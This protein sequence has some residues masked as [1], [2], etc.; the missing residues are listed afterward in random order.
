MSDRLRASLLLLVLLFPFTI[1]NSNAHAAPVTDRPISRSSAVMFVENVD[2]WP[3]AARFQ[4]RSGGATLWLAESALWITLVE[5]SVDD[6]GRALGRSAPAH[7]PQDAGLNAERI[8]RRGANIRLSFVDGKSH[9][10]LEPFDRLDTVVS[11]FTSNDPTRWRP[12]VPAWG[13]VRYADLYP[14]IDFEVTSEGG[15]LIHRLAARPG[16]DLAAVTLRVE[17][18]DDVAIAGHVLRL[19]AAGRD[20]IFPLPR[21]DGMLPAGREAHAGPSVEAL[22]AQTFDVR[23]P[24]AGSPGISPPARSE[25]F[26]SAGNSDRVL[27]STFLGGSDAD[28]GPEIAVDET[29]SAYLAGWT[30]SSDF[31][32][33][34]GAFDPSHNGG[35][36]VYVAKLNPNGSALAYATFLGGGEDKDPDYGD[37]AYGVAVDE[38]GC[39]HVVGMTNSSDFPTTPGAFDTSHNGGYDGFV[40]KLDPTGAQL[41]YATLL[42]GTSND[43]GHDIALDG[44]GGAHVI[45]V[46]YSADFPVTSGVFDASYNGQGSYG[47]TFVA[48]LDP[49]GSSLTHATFLGGSSVDTGAAIAVDGSGDIYVAGDTNSAD[50]PATL[51]AYDTSHNG[52]KD[53]F[54]VKLNAAASVLRYATFIGGSS[55]DFGRDFA[56]DAAGS[57]YVTGMTVSGD[58]PTTPGAWDR[59]LGA[60]DAYVVKLDSAG[61]QL[62][63]ATLLGG[64]SD[65]YGD[66]IAVDSTGNAYVTGGTASDDFPLTPGA[67]DTTYGGGTCDTPAEHYPCGDA[68]AVKLEPDGSALADGT[69]LGGADYDH[70]YGIAV[71]TAG[72]MYVTGPTTSADFVTTPGAFDVEVGYL[73]RFVTKLKPSSY[74]PSH[75]RWTSLASDGAPVARA[76]HSAVWTGSEMIV[77]GGWGGLP[78]DNTFSD[79]GRYDPRT[80][81][82]RAMSTGNAPSARTKQAAVWTG[83]EMIVWGG[84]GQVWMPGGFL[85]DGGRYNPGTDTWAPL[86]G[87][88]AP[89]ARRP[90]AA[91]WTGSELIVWGGY[92]DSFLDDGAAYNP[93]TDRW[94]SISTEGAPAGRDQAAAIWTGS[95][96]IVWGGFGGGYRNDGARYDPA[97][98][99]WTPV[100]VEGAPSART[101]HTAI[102]TGS[103]M[104]IWGGR[105]GGLLDDGAAYDPV[106]DSWAALP[107]VDAPT[108]RANH[109]AVWNGSD[110]LVWGGWSGQTSGDGKRYNPEIRR[111]TALPAEGAPS[112]RWLHTAVWSGSEM[113][114]WGGMDDSFPEGGTILNDGASFGEQHTNYLPLLLK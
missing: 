3:S 81:R 87:A 18:A 101:A 73:D 23:A 26:A 110:M 75:A 4:A 48:R 27:Y 83:A 58:F 49:L 93:A 92:N 28:S 11:Y 14:G 95:E 111:W 56:V 5:S 12:A 34:F 72:S 41:A 45:G 62:G 51:G 54:V 67:A 112:A 88:G 109:S 10:R 36:D 76:D 43:Y 105:A 107:M 44:S 90:A 29:G 89:S 35:N 80:R 74:R 2:Q 20:F 32:A 61:S 68:F 15:T 37:R 86:S 98:D 42:G 97:A 22:G 63:Y 38:Q 79:G 53:L 7:D 78:L 82:W 94:R 59:S 64:S 114:I 70:G 39:A 19:R 84:S 69:Y 33:T 8:E 106:T 113:L 65:E 103:V 16:A 9:P 1:A 13:G 50:F 21:L 85:N 57:A 52:G 66:G 55:E 91:V 47:D 102:W 40:V 6:A 25:L 60:Y 24:F 71:D 46:T 17:G 30:Y 104:I 31:P 108:A 77:W 99:R 96:M 100:A